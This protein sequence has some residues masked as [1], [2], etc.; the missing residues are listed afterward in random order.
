M[1]NRWCPFV[2]L[3]GMTVLNIMSIN[4]NALAGKGC[5]Y[6]PKVGGGYHTAWNEIPR[7]YALYGYVNKPIVGKEIKAFLNETKDLRE[8][9]FI[10]KQQLE[11]ELDKSKP[12][13][14]LA[15][16]LQ[17]QIS[18]LQTVFDQKWIR[19]IIKMKALDPNFKFKA[20]STDKGYCGY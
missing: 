11:M 17:S 18:K 3:I 5:G 1:K 8:Q 10:K 13:K 9:L 12:D 16:N 19:H 14:G 7:N 4:T 15:M 20:T 6:Q 2:I